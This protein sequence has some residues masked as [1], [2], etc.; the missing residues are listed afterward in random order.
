M[1]ID[2]GAVSATTGP[3]EVYNN[4]SLSE[5]V[6]EAAGTNVNVWTGGGGGTPNQVL[7]NDITGVASG[8]SLDATLTTAGSSPDFGVAGAGGNFTGT[9][10]PLAASA[11]ASTATVDGLFI[12]DTAA[13]TFFISGL[14]DGLT[15]NLLGFVGRD[16]NTGAQAPTS[17]T[18]GTGG[19]AFWQSQDGTITA[20]E[21]TTQ[22][23]NGTAGGIAF[24]WNG[25]SPTSGQ[26][27]FTM[28]SNADLLVDIKALSI[29]AV[30]E[31]SSLALLPIG[32]AGM[33][34]RRRR[35]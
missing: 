7:L 33:L 34:A 23:P 28:G 15:Y 32:V 11:F 31:P 19:S 16:N 20:G 10:A 25:V 6:D 12:Q 1:K 17:L 26:I 5:N 4:I 3:G 8:W 18:T 24:G 9:V 30:P 29:T 14:N 35:C 22:D 13:I 21:L 27:A 2:F